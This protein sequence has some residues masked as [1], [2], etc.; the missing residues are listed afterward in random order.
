MSKA[1]RIGR[2][3]LSIAL[4]TMA[5]SALLL[6][7]TASLLYQADRKAERASMEIQSH[8]DAAHEFVNEWHEEHRA[9]PDASEFSSWRSRQPSPKPPNGAVAFYTDWYPDE[10]VQRV[11][12][13]R[14][15]EYALAVSRGDRLVVES[16]S[17]RMAR[18]GPREGRTRS[19]VGAMGVYVLVCVGSMVLASWVWPKSGVE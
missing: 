15:G 3:V 18:S 12:E 5:V 1:T 4:L 10:V 6:A 8:L 11:G 17:N 19:F 14:D 7:A 16:S 2:R 13:P 9:L